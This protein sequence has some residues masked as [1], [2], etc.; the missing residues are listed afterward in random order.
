[1]K[2]T[3]TKK[4]VDNSKL[5]AMNSPHLVNNTQNELWLYKKFLNSYLP[6]VS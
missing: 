4:L 6:V 5:N 1:M 2:T 3:I